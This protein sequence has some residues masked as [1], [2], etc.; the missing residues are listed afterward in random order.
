MEYKDYYKILGVDKNASQN[1]IK[2]AFRRLAIKFHP[3]KNPGNKEAENKFKSVN[4]ANEVLGDPVKRKKYDELGKNWNKFNDAGNF[5][6]GNQSFYGRQR[7]KNE[8]EFDNDRNF[9]DI[10]STKQGDLGF[11]DF[12]ETFFRNSDPSVNYKGAKKTQQRGED[13]EIIIELT[14]EEAYRGTSRI[15]QLENEKIRI[16]IKPGVNDGQLLRIRGKGKPGANYSD[17]GDLIV[18]ISIRPHSIFKRN[19]DDILLSHTLDLFTALLGGETIVNTVDGKIKV[20]I[21]EGTQNG[22]NIRIKGKGMPAYEQ[23]NKYGDLIVH[24]NIK[25]PEKLTTKQRDLLEQ[26]RG[27][28]K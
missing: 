25:I 15:I 24:L 4:E 12:F 27:S 23:K 5:S 21:Q 13:Y 8:W 6:R 18:R 17:Y 9:F 7:N 28:F 11:S 19:G 20:K 26:I 14:L 16:S 22:K 10:F 2:K 1:E 3:D